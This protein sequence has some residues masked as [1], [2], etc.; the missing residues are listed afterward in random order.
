MAG[1]EALVAL[2]RARVLAAQEFRGLRVAPQIQ[3]PAGGRGRPLALVFDR[4]VDVEARQEDAVLPDF[5]N[6]GVLI[7]LPAAREDPLAQVTLEQ[8]QDLRLALPAPVLLADLLALERPEGEQSQGNGREQ[9][10]P[11]EKGDPARPSM[12]APEV[13]HR[14]DST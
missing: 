11:A 7:G 6:K 8:A 1:T 2:F 14:H 12:H 10:D 5:K 9:D 3:V 13:T 4:Q